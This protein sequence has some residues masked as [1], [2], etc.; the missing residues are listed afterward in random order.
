M[1]E[2]SEITVQ[3]LHALDGAVIIDVREVSEFEEGHAAGAVNIPTSELADRIDELPQNGEQFF[4]I[5]HGGGRSG[6]ATVALRARDYN[7]VNILGGT[8]GWADAGFAIER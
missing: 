1:N 2:I 8:V 4:L 6:R 7:A 5:C 3:D